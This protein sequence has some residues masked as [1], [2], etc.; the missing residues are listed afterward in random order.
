M[1]VLVARPFERLRLAGPRHS[2]VALAP[3]R[4]VMLLMAI[5]A[6]VALV[7]TKLAWFAVVTTPT[8]TRSVAD[9]LVPLRGDI[10]DRNGVPLARTID[11]WSI[12]VHPQ[13]L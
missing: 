11:A 7:L 10:T 13:R 9:A 6:G 4:L 2:I 12:G 8:S 1:S 3:A 5:A